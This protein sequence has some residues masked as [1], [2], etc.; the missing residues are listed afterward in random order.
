MLRLNLYWLNLWLTS[1]MFVWATDTMAIRSITN[2]EKHRKEEKGRTHKESSDKVSNT[3]VK[4]SQAA[5]MGSDAQDMTTFTEVFDSSKYD[6]MAEMKKS[7]DMQEENLK[8]VLSRDEKEEPFQSTITYVQTSNVDM[9]SFP[10]TTTAVD[11]SQPNL[12]EKAAELRGSKQEQIVDNSPT[13]SREKLQ[14]DIV[15]AK[16]EEA[17]TWP[18]HGLANPYTLFSDVA[19]S[20]IDLYVESAR[21]VAVITG[22]WLDLFSKPWPVGRG[23]KEINIE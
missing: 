15:E 12:E 4:D 3:T 7:A 19:K 5:K 9:N 16:K 1:V 11:A 6:S 20:W 2:R 8:E 13:D 23:T 21:N 10:S 22:H 14:E 17:E 18:T